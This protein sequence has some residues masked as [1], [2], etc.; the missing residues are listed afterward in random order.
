MALTERFV[1]LL[2]SEFQ[3]P[4]DVP[5]APET[6][7]SDL[8]GVGQSETLAKLQQR[9]AAQIGTTPELAEEF[10]N[11]GMETDHIG[12][13]GEDSGA[14]RTVQRLSA[15]IDHIHASAIPDNGSD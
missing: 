6:N 14:P 8:I 5:I 3:I 4:T 11:K 10:F 13:M 7:F 12:E 1:R 15:M 9:L 2:R